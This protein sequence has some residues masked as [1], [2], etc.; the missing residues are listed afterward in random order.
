MAYAAYAL[1]TPHHCVTLG[2]T[3]LQVAKKA[4]L[5]ISRREKRETLAAVKNEPPDAARYSVQLLLPILD[6]VIWFIDYTA[7]HRFLRD[8]DE[9]TQ[10]TGC[11]ATPHRVYHGS[12]T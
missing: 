1:T 2:L 11:V 5:M 12:K 10:V 9:T 6:R 4:V 7:E 8:A 3:V